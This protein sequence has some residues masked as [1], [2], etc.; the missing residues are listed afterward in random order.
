MEESMLKFY[1]FD[2]GNVMDGYLTKFVGEYS[3]SELDDARFDTRRYSIIRKENYNRLVGRE[4][5]SI[6]RVKSKEN[7]D[8]E[9]I[10]FPVFGLEDLG[11]LYITTSN[12]YALKECLSPK[13]LKWLEK[14]REGHKI[15]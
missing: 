12:H 13:Q 1:V 9:D 15:L 8:W 11:K 6:L 14:N 5:I 10:Y 3:L 7:R 2:C 4:P